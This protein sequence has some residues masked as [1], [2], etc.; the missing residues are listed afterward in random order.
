FRLGLYEDVLSL[1]DLYDSAQSDTANYMTD[2]NEAML[3]ISGDLESSGMTTDD[4]IKQKDANIL[5]LESGTDVMGNKTQLSA[6]YIY[7]QYDVA[8]AEA[9]KDRVR[10]DIHEIAMIPDLNDEQFSGKIGRAHV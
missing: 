1:I 10:K 2:L 9:Y 4:A 3:V 5:L 7:K 6:N 8:G